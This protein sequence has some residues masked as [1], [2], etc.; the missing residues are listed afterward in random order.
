[1]EFWE[2]LKNSG[3][4]RAD[5]GVARVCAAPTTNLNLPVKFFWPQEVGVRFFDGWGDKNFF[6]DRE[7]FFVDGGNIFSWSDGIFFAVGKWEFP[8]RKP[9]I[10]QPLLATTP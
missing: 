10:L 5:S 3:P 7:S 4:V 6:R 1:M 2:L 8:F 9:L